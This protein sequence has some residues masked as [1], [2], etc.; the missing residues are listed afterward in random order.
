MV[1]IEC[2][3]T[4][5]L[6]E[7]ERKVLDAILLQNRLI[8]APLGMDKGKCACLGSISGWFGALMVAFMVT[9]SG[10]RVL[11]YSVVRWK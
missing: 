1:D 3:D 2:Q 9:V 4:E 6:G 10:L 5:W 8:L 7:R 11:G